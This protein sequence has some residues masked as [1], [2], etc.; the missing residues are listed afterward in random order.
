VEGH[1]E[2]TLA[3]S[4]GI[5]PQS[6]LTAPE[7]VSR[8]IDIPSAEITTVTRAVFE[9]ISYRDNPDGWLGIFPI[10]KT[11]LDDLKMSA[12]PLVIVAE[13]VE[14]PGNLGA[15][16]RTADAAHV[17]ALLVCD[18]RVDLWNPNVVRASRGAVFTVPTVEVDSS[19][20]LAWLRSKGTRVL[21]ATPSAEVLYTSVNL[22]QPIAIAVGTEDEGLTDFWMQSADIKVKIPMLGKVKCFDCNGIDY[23]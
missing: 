12:S 17:D 4:S 8:S 18:P 14:K 3:L 9:K 15:I 5:K 16:L 6:L 13:S 20:A 23:L 19:T 2:L 1:D 10:P 11:A 21:A 22:N 7:L